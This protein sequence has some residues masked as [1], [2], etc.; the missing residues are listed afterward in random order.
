M[1]RAKVINFKKQIPKNDLSV[2]EKIYNWGEEKTHKKYIK[3]QIKY[4]RKIYTII[5]RKNTIADGLT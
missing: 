5:I 2:L 1:K 3:F 4:L